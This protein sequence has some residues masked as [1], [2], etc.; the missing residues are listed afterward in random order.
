MTTFN[1]MATH[2]VIAQRHENYH[3]WSTCMCVCCSLFRSFYLWCIEIHL[4]QFRLGI[5]PNATKIMPIKQA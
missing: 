2:R 4:Q 1:L 5:V 3:S